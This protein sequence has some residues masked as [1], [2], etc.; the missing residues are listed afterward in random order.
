[1]VASAPTAGVNLPA[2][3]TAAIT[4]LACE[5]I[6]LIRIQLHLVAQIAKLEEA[7]L[8]PNDPEDLHTILGFALGG[9]VAEEGGKQ[10]AKATGVVTRK[11]IRKKISKETLAAV[12]KWGSK[13]GIKVLQRSIIKFAVPVASVLTGRY[14]G[15]TLPRCELVG[16]PRNTLKTAGENADH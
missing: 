14:S 11:F 12:K 3:I 4:A 7:S 2:H 13:V 6:V 9:A 1:M 10:V 8:D 15:T 5:A 16:S